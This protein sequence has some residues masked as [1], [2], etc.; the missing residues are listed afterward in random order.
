MRSLR[1]LERCGLRLSDLMVQKVKHCTDAVAAQHNQSSRAPLNR[2]WVAVV[3]VGALCTE[4]LLYD[5]V[6]AL[7]KR[8]G[9]TEFLM[10][11]PFESLPNTFF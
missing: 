9:V 11:E 8:L 10:Q 7:F 2:R 5:S 3:V 4:Y 1:T 6:S